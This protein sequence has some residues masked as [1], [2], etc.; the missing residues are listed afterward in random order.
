MTRSILHIG[1]CVKVYRPKYVNA[2][3]LWH[4]ALIPWIAR[5][6]GE[7]LVR[8]AGDWKW[9]DTR[10][11][12]VS[13]FVRDD[14]GRIIGVPEHGP[15]DALRSV[16][17]GQVEIEGKTLRDVVRGVRYIV[18]RLWF[19]HVGWPIRRELTRIRARIS[20]WIAP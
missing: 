19:S 7:E 5:L 4:S 12:A 2:D 3:R 8:G 17:H 11:G 9:A 1:A 13:V 10:R 6:D 18:R 15:E 16:Q 20:R 14:D